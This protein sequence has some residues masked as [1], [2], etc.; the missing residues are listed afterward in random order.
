M[1]GRVSIRTMRREEYPL[2]RRYL[3]LAIFVPEGATP[4]PEDTCDKPELQVYL[5]D[6]G[7]SP[8]DR[9]LVAEEGGRV[10]GAV[11]TR[12]LDDYGHVDDETP[13]F[14]ISLE[15]EARG[16]GIGT[17]L[18]RAMLEALGAAGYRQASLAVQKANRALR[19]YKKVGF[20]TVRE[21]EEEYIMV[22]RLRGA[23]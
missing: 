21:N 5:K 20:E 15:A 22:C 14:A 12:I 7:E 23:P 9:C 16:R 13:S 19:L 17:A 8:H 2:L 3:Y 10:V 11:W 6:F 4:P 1:A 18:M